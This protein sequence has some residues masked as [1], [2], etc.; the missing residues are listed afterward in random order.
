[1]KALQLSL[2]ASLALATT[3]AASAQNFDQCGTVE[4]G[5]TC[6][7]LFRADDQTLWILDVPLTAYQIGDR[8]R[9]SGT[10]DPFCF[11]TCQQG[12]GCIVGSQLSTCGL[13]P[14]LICAPGI[15]NSTGQ[16]GGIEATGSLRL[17]DDDLTLTGVRLPPGSF[18]YFLTSTTS[19]APIPMPGGSQGNL[20]LGG[21]IGRFQAQVGMVDAAGTYRISTDPGAGAQRFSFAAFPQPLGPVPVMAGETWHF[22]CWHRDVFQGAATSNF[23]EG[24][25]LLFS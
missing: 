11:S 24:V 4:A 2:A 1:M 7:R 22:Q 9:V 5:V 19:V 12:D 17:V 16:I 10:T 8:L 25:S 18:A 15:P 6:P 23:T 21:S 13:M 20:C 3:L 14:P